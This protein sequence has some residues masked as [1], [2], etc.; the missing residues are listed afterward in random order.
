MAAPTEGQN[1][2]K[3]LANGEPST[4]GAKRTSLSLI[5]SDRDVSSPWSRASNKNF[6]FLLA[7]CANL[8]PEMSSQQSCDTLRQP[9]EL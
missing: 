4:H 5:Q 3:I 7:L 1:I 6:C 2:M 9:P 8:F